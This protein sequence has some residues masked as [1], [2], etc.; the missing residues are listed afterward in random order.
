MDPDL[1]SADGLWLPA[2]DLLLERTQSLPGHAQ[3]PTSPS[4]A[5]LAAAQGADQEASNAAAAIMDALVCK[6]KV[7]K[8]A[9][10][11]VFLG[12]LFGEDV[13]VKVVMGPVMG[14]GTRK[15]RQAWLREKRTALVL[16]RR[17]HRN[18]LRYFAAFE[19]P[20]D[21]QDGNISEGDGVI[22]MERGSA[23]QV[24]IGPREAPTEPIVW[25]PEQR[26]EHALRAG[27]V[28]VSLT[29]ALAHLH[30]TVKTIHRDVKPDNALQVKESEGKRARICLCDFSAARTQL[31]HLQRASTTRHIGTM[32]YLAPE[33]HERSITYCSR[34]DMWSLGCTALTF[35]N[36]GRAASAI[37]RSYI[38]LAHVLEFK[39]GD[40]DKV[41]NAYKETDGVIANSLK[42]MMPEESG[43]VAALREVLILCLR[44]DPAQ[45]PSTAGLLRSPQLLKLAEL[46]GEAVDNLGSADMLEDLL[47]DE[48]EK[49]VAAADLIQD[50]LERFGHEGTPETQR[51]EAGPLGMLRDRMHRALE[52][53]DVFS[54]ELLSCWLHLLR[55]CPEASVVEAD[56]DKAR[57]LL[58]AIVQN[59]SP[60]D[61]LE[62][63]EDH[64]EDEEVKTQSTVEEDWGAD[65]SNGSVLSSIIDQR[66]ED[67]YTALQLASMEAKSP[68]ICLR[69]L[70]LGADV[71]VVDSEGLTPIMRCA[72][73]GYELPPERR[74]DILLVLRAFGAEVP[75]QLK[76]EV[77]QK[78]F[79]SASMREALMLSPEKAKERVKGWSEEL[80]KAKRLRR[81]CD[82]QCMNDSDMLDM[83][84][85]QSAPAVPS[86][87]NFET[88]DVSSQVKE[89]M[90][91]P[92]IATLRNQLDTA[93]DAVIS[94]GKAGLR[95]N[96]SEPARESAN[97]PALEPVEC[98]A[99]T[100]PST[101][102]LPPLD[103]LPV[104]RPGSDSRPA[105]EDPEKE[106]S[107][108]GEDEPS[109]KEATAPELLRS[110]T[111]K[112]EDDLKEYLLA[113]SHNHMMTAFRLCDRKGKHR[114]TAEEFARMLEHAI[115]G[116]D[117]EHLRRRL[118]RRWERGMDFRA[119]STWIR[120]PSTQGQGAAASSSSRR[121]ASAERVPEALP[122]GSVG[123]SSSSRPG[124]SRTGSKGRS[125]PPTQ[126][127]PSSMRPVRT[128]PS[129]MRPP[130]GSRSI[131]S[132]TALRT[133][134]PKT[135]KR[136]SGAGL[137]GSQEAT[138][139]LQG[140]L[141]QLFHLL[142][143]DN[144]GALTNEEFV[145]AQTKVAEASGS[146]DEETFALS[147]MEAFEEADA[148][149]NDMIELEEWLAWS[150]GTFVPAIPLSKDMLIS[151]LSVM[152]ASM[153][154]PAG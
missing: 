92:S 95:A 103:T 61:L 109:K 54:A 29:N 1:S 12:Q 138:A 104:L 97:K 10:G 39:R 132:R 144:D 100:R 13:A 38:N 120:T 128:A 14:S 8:G 79:F 59:Q 127:A 148:N 98:D 151:R 21:S 24:P 43:P 44:A 85:K 130:S 152:L 88:E 30:C 74:T 123:A 23:L 45:R 48:V 146:F 46:V 41:M 75:N 66:D 115:P 86:T 26:P 136:L 131:S 94:K 129:S 34:V 93:V 143:G 63:L 65:I 17:P 87:A 52:E 124:S 91:Q 55:R 116:T 139:R 76:F 60:E 99:E 102:M 125:S 133:E 145:L 19:A 114:V 7:G 82:V 67:G 112:Q 134:K 122:H 96:A 107:H 105:T 126:T 150:L 69:L 51:L 101:P 84:K 121:S 147:A 47:E 27:Q 31:Y 32:G 89:L 4:G 141:L 6:T 11:D 77:A 83:R 149:G 111:D 154:A 20:V 40:N 72:M 56:R 18:C 2:Y 119:F 49:S 57:T 22:I 5:L 15:V 58:H 140:H 68:H 113:T 28:L 25:S 73:K 117:S 142:D 137:R 36:D 71:N 3:G 42:E 135:S 118:R 9:A 64:C 35:F 106:A 110:V 108:T 37:R 62:L 78:R 16:R 90:Q 81:L 153:S 70:E 33:M 53:K 80:R 50:L